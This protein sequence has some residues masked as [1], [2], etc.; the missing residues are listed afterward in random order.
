MSTLIKPKHCW[1]S[2]FHSS[3]LPPLTYCSTHHDYYFH[4]HYALCQCQRD[5][6]LSPSV[7]GS[8]RI[9]FKQTFACDFSSSLRVAASSP[10]ECLLLLAVRVGSEDV[11]NL[12]LPSFAKRAGL[13]AHVSCLFLHRVAL[14]VSQLVSGQFPFPELIEVQH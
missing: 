5:L 1:V 7:S 10:L 8:H 3:T 13:F 14:S 11:N 12:C 9:I 4:H 6:R 2:S